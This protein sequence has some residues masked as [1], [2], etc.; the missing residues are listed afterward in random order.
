M[1]ALETRTIE[2][3]KKLVIIIA[4]LAFLSPFYFLKPGIED[5]WS[6]WMDFTN[7]DTYYGSVEARWAHAST[8]FL[9]EKLSH[10]SYI[11]SGVATAILR[12]RKDNLHT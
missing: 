9:I 11:Y 12:Q 6:R 4:I 2:M 7:P 8:D 1:L 5:L 10:P 3:N